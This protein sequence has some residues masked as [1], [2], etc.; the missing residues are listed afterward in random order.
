MVPPG[1]ELINSRA[2]TLRNA[3]ESDEMNYMIEPWSEEERLAAFATFKKISENNRA[4]LAA[5][6]AGRTLSDYPMPHDI[7]EAHRLTMKSISSEAGIFDEQGRI[8]LTRRPSATEDPAEPYPNQ[9]HIPGT[10]HIGN[11]TEVEAF[12]RLVKDEIGADIEMHFI[13]HK[14]YHTNGHNGLSLLY[15]AHIHSDA[16]TTN[17]RQQWFNARALPAELLADHI[18][19][20]GYLTTHLPTKSSS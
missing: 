5:R 9:W 18:A 7:Y 16:V 11:E 4:W 1:A 20:V 12:Q 2:R 6:R 13:G 14:E 17:E 3:S 15:L 19:I 8:F 10:R